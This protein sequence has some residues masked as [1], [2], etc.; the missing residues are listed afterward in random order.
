VRNALIVFKPF[1]RGVARLFS[2]SVNGS[3]SIRAVASDRET[4]SSI[5]NSKK[6]RGYSAMMTGSRAILVIGNFDIPCTLK[7][8]MNVELIVAERGDCPRELDL[9]GILPVIV[10]QF[11]QKCG[12]EPTRDEVAVG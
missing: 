8:W 10:I 6:R 12:V 3:S 11:R 1:L 5:M 7:S 9:L 4:G 2:S